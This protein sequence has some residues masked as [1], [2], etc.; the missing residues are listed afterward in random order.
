M[1][2]PPHKAVRFK[3]ADVVHPRPLQVLLELFRHYS[4]EGEIVAATSDGETRYVVCRVAGLEDAVIVARDRTT[5]VFEDEAE[6]LT[7]SGAEG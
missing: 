5:V 2:N 3:V 7:G 6:E 1:D 4:L